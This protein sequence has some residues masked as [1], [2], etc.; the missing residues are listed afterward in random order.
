MLRAPPWCAARRQKGVWH[1]QLALSKSEIM[2]TLEIMV[3]EESDWGANLGDW[4]GEIAGLRAIVRQISEQLDGV[5]A[6][7]A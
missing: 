1:S 6:A 4:K 7:I 5:V 2:K 3:L